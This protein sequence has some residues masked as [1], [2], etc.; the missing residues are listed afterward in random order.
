MG[1]RARKL[2]AGGKKKSGVGRG[3]HPNESVVRYKAT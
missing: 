3:K 1:K 2:S